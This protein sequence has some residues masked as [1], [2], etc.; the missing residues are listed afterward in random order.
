MSASPASVAAAP[1]RPSAET[2]AHITRRL[3]PILLLIYVMSFLDRTNLGLAQR[4]LE[5][6][7]GISAAA[8]GLGAGLFFLTY[9]VFEVP[10]N[11]ILA[12][13]GARLWLFRIAITWGIIAIAMAFVWNE[14]SFYVMRL[15][16][17]AAEAGLYPG[18]LFFLTKW[19][20]HAER[21]KIQGMFILGAPIAS[22]IGGPLGGALLQLD[23]ASGFHGWQWMFVIEGIPTLILAFVLLAT[24]PDRP[25]KAKWLDPLVA[26]Q[27]EDFVE[28]ENKAGAERSGNHNFLKVL[29]DR[30][31]LVIAIAYFSTQV[32]VYSLSY[33][34]PSIIAQIGT[35][36]NN[37]VI[38]VLSAVPWL[39]GG[40]GSVLITRRARSRNTS[41][42]WIIIS[43]A[44]AVVG[45]A[46][47]ASVGAWIGFIGFCF[48]GFFMVAPQA[49]L[50]SLVGLRMQGMVLA[51][52]IAA[53]NT[54]GLIGGF[55]GPYAMGAMQSATGGNAA[56]G[57]W[58]IVGMS[59]IG[60]L[61]SF[62]LTRRAVV[63]FKPPA[64]EA[65]EA[66]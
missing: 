54:F 66:R 10:S 49:L 50:L 18:V 45:L 60:L 47:A 14:T 30:Q 28:A 17:G 16:L 2:I 35:F 51:A 5:A 20:P 15:L 22:V 43:L 65:G 53:V 59:A 44:A 8:Y 11:L 39:F 48:F 21:A 41:R 27:V 33:F 40:I 62:M 7:L 9:A 64:A 56:S 6:D 4:D 26:Q 61:L 29:R 63:D 13:V 42:F 25:T 3:L 31:I 37:V 12:K 1:Q 52:G 55:A 19:Y 58:L 38:G 34:L 32:A 57:V 46:V 24:L 23:G 36:D